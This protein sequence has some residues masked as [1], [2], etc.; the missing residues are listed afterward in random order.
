MSVVPAR[1]GVGSLMTASL[2]LAGRLS[3]VLVAR[4]TLATPPPPISSIRGAVKK[5]TVV[6]TLQLKAIQD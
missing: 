1:S 5:D 3:V 4:P 6:G 2:G